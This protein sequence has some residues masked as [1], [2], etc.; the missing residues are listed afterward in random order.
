M[1]QYTRMSWQG[2]RLWTSRGRRLASEGLRRALEHTLGVSKRQVPLEEG[3][4]ERSGKVDVDGLDGSI[5]YDTVYARRQHEEMDWK[6]LPGRK[7][8]YLEDPMI[9]ER[10]TMLRLMAVSMRRWLRG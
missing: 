1:T 5:S 2:D 9:S 7:A 10:D 3:T 4:L 8:K 6:H